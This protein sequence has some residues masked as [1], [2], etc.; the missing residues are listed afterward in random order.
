M[1]AVEAPDDPAVVGDAEV[2]N[3]AL[4]GEMPKAHDGEGDDEGD[5]PDH[6]RYEATGRDGHGMW[7]HRVPPTARYAGPRAGAKGALVG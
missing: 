7:R 1:R 4:R 3:R 2:S 6:K 5:G